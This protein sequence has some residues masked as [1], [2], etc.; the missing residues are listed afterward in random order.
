MIAIGAALILGACASTPEPTTPT[1]SITDL[2]QSYLAAPSALL[3]TGMDSNLDATIEKTEL[4]EHST[5]LFELAD[6]DDN[7]AVSPVE[8]SSW[9]E[10][11]L[12]AAYANPG[13][14]HFD[15]NQDKVISSEE[16]SKTL[17]RLFQRFDKDGSQ[18][19]ARSELIFSV[20]GVNKDA[21]RQ[22]VE[23]TVKRRIQDARRNR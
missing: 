9:S 21:V 13:L 4:I 14:L 8:L 17:S 7:G 22:E 23:E 20:E 6:G 11:Y 10:H 3:L 16:F 1:R 2:E 19:L 5:A 12:G 15:Q 18:S